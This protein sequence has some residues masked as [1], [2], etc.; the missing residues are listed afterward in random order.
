MLPC[1]LGHIGVCAG[2]VSFRELEIEHWL[3]LGL[4]LASTICRPSS[5]VTFPRLV[6]FPVLES[7]Q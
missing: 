7:T 5:L 1:A 2:E 6:R 3:T 4:I